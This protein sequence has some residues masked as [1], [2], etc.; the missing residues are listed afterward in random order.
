MSSSRIPDG[1]QSF[2]RHA[3]S[4]HPSNNARGENGFAREF[5][6][7][8]DMSSKLKKDPEY[9]THHGELEY[10]RP[11]NRYKDIVPFDHNRIVL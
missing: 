6:Q 2:L 8:K 10:N 5:Q 9:S 11:K 1:L 7:L 4:L 3:E